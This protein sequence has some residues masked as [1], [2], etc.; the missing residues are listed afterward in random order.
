MNDYFLHVR[1][2]EKLDQLRKEGMTSQEFHR[3]GGPARRVLPRSATLVGLMVLFLGAVL[4]L[5]H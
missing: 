3:L 1:S 5:A 2:R 4:I